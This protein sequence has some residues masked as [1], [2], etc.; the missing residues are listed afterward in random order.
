MR[1]PVIGFP[2][3][4]DSCNAAVYYKIGMPDGQGE[5]ARLPAVAA[6]VLVLELGN[7]CRKA[8]E[9]SKYL[10]DDTGLSAVSRDRFGCN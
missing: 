3:V 10:F 4:F 5:K 7:S 9:A 2:E 8:A 1:T 6:P